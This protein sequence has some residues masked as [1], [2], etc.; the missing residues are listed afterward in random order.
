MPEIR[1]SLYNKYQK[2]V[3]RRKHRNRLFAV[4]SIIILVSTVTALI[5][6]AI[7]D[8]NKTYCG[9]EEH[10]HNDECYEETLFCNLGDEPDTITESPPT[11]IEEAPTQA[12]LPLT[13]VEE[14]STEQT[15]STQ[16]ATEAPR[17]E[18]TESPPTTT[19]S[20]HEHDD[21]CYELTLIC[22]KEE[23]THSLICMSDPSADVETAEDWRASLNGLKLTGKPGDDILEVAKTQ[24]GYMESENHYTVDEDGTTKNSYNRYGAWYGDPYGSWNSTF[25]S[26]CAYYAKVD[27]IIK[28]NNC[29]DWITTLKAESSDLY[30]E[31]NQYTPEPGDI[32]F[33]DR[34]SNNTPD[35]VGIISEINQKSGKIKV[36]EGD[37]E[38]KVGTSSYVLTDSTIFC[39][40]THPPDRSDWDV[41]LVQQEITATI[42]TDESHL[43][44]SDDQTKITIS[45]LLPQG[46]SGSAHPVKLESSF[47]QGESLIAAYDITIRDGN[48]NL[49]SH[50]EE[51]QDLVVTIK[52]PE[53]PDD[54]EDNYSVYHIADKGKSESMV[55]VENDSDDTISFRTDH[56][57]V[58]ALTR[59]GTLTEVYLNGT[60]GNDDSDGSKNSPVKT[61]EAALSL[62]APD[63]T[64]Y[65][66]GNVT[67]NNTQT[68]SLGS[69]QKIQRESSYT[70]P[71]I[72]VS[73]GGN[74]SLSNII[75]NGGSD[76]PS[77]SNIATNSTYADG[78][79][80]APLVVI[81]TGGTVNIKD[82]AV[83]EYNSNEP[84]ISNNKFVESG[85][86]GLGGAVYCSGTLNMTGGLIQYCEAQCGGGVYVENGSF[87]M[88]GGTI[89]HNYARDIVSYRNRMENYH[90]NAGGGVYLGDYATMTLS[91]G[92]VSNNQS[93][94]E[95]GGI[96]LG[97]LNRS[98]NSAIYEYITTFTMTGGLITENYA[99]STG[100]GL[101]ITAGREAIISAGSITYN[102]A[103]GKEYQDSD[104]YVNAGTYCQVYSGGGIYL[105]SQ[106]WDSRGNAAGVPAKCTIN[107]VIITDN[108]ATNSGGGIASCSTA[109]TSVSYNVNL[110]NGTAIY[111]NTAKSNGNELYIS[112][113]ANIGNTVLGG[114]SYNWSKSG[115][116]YDNSLTDSSS[117]IKT[118]YELY[119]VMISNNTGYLGG[120]IGC[121]GIIFVGGEED[122]TSLSI[123]KVWVD[124]PGAPRPEFITVQ[125]LQNG[126]P[127]GDPIKIY[128]TIGEDGKEEWPIYYIDGLPENYT[129]TIQEIS[130]PGYT[131][132]ITTSSRHHTITNTAMGFAVVKEWVGDDESDR[133]KTL[134]VQLYQNGTPYGEVQTLSAD[135]RWAYMWF[136]LPETDE[137]GDPYVYTV[138]EVSVPDGYI[139]TQ[140]G[141]L[142]ENGV[143]EIEN[144]KIPNTSVSAEKK[145]ADGVAGTDS[146]TLQ[147]MANGVEYG[148]PI[149]LNADNDWFYLWENLPTLTQN[150]EPITYTVKEERVHGYETQITTST[151]GPKKT[152]WVT[153]TSLSSGNTYLLVSS[154]GALSGSTS[155]QLK[156]VDVTSHLANGTLPDD[157][158]L[159]TYRS[160][161]LSN[162]DGKYL[163]TQY[164]SR[165]YTFRATTSGSNIA[166]SNSRLYTS[167]ST[168]RYFT[169]I[170]SSGYGT[171]ATN[172]SSAK[173]FTAYVLSETTKAIGETHYV[174]TNTK[175]ENS[176]TIWFTKYIVKE[177]INEAF[178]ILPGAELALYCETE[179]GI[180]IPGTNVSGIL[181]DEWTSE[182][183]LEDSRGAYGVDLTDGI[184]YLV[185]TKAPDGYA[186]LSGPIIFQVDTSESKI[187]ILQYPGFEDIIFSN[188][189]EG[190]LEGSG[191]IDFPVYNATTYVLPE[192]GGIG[193]YIYTLGGLILISASFILL[194]YQYK[195]HRKEDS[196]FS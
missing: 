26:F 180:I 62:L 179:D 105:D 99:T 147:L 60:S 188:T 136:D 52:H 193:T 20:K 111:N 168:S 72:T 174:V 79:A 122:T 196:E 118:A 156:W 39:Y 78:S 123:E 171:T 46:A 93:S 152:E 176:L 1:P 130:V 2:E 8:S 164:S 172:S 144:T 165:T 67:V 153:S 195:K 71:L 59:S 55:M 192:T 96:S 109:N 76:T 110:G 148:N 38:G 87:S 114:G 187:T 129:Y 142:N 134:T 102:V 125:I 19:Q 120:G 190:V 170:N 166:Y 115:G 18:A 157:A 41:P 158:A 33:F 135:N 32:I 57:S 66:S 44:V 97:W 106:Q 178:P 42:Y 53:L 45:G 31:K 14:P 54:D 24:V 75:I 107:R 11:H 104:T 177:D 128:P 185:E 126:I 159:W 191:S 43:T 173:S 81:N 49:F 29:V 21:S 36:I 13:Q 139:C 121:N 51:Y 89:D 65:I 9:F 77:S 92:T 160:N 124:A 83:L 17:V 68:W 12:D 5:L 63:G 101:N 94:R 131:S 70:G 34:D 73:S 155:D 6:P 84:N 95:G 86:I 4:F 149:K 64:I 194:L 141:K 30:H 150:S 138:R 56:F 22:E 140:S 91:G 15:E 151:V 143:W 10:Q 163:A 35:W 116:Y 80:K 27:T 189:E 119:T 3:K 61:F 74:L 28:S 133:P 117:A 103:D 132:Q 167:G 184:Y 169:G 85:Y 82:G 161:K 16:E 154:D 175:R 98:N 25:V 90:K 186:K 88:A 47:V 127:Y 23:H 108:T 182:S 7:S 40:I 183:A 137:N 50:T 181:V 58:F 113:T 37:L 112:G 48:G 100:G 162:G 69:G 145:W 146:I